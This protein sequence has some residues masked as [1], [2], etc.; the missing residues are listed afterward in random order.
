ML[1][2]P[3]IHQGSCAKVSYLINPEEVQQ[4]FNDLPFHIDSNT[5]VRPPS[6]FAHITR[7]SVCRTLSYVEPRVDSAL[8]VKKMSDCSCPACEGKQEQEKTED[9]EYF[10]SCTFY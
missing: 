3:T 7:T 4:L 9:D 5:E 10:M 2:R 1:V 8:C 6:I